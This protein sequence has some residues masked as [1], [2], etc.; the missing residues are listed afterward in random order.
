[1][2]ISLDRGLVAASLGSC[3]LSSSASAGVSVPPESGDTEA[4]GGKDEAG[5]AA[6]WAEW[7]GGVPAEG[8]V[9]AGESYPL[10]CPSGS[11]LA[12]SWECES[13][14]WCRTWYRS[15]GNQAWV[16]G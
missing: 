6:A 14:W 5:R 10:P 15:R 11:V 8:V 4:D 2:G 13:S 16:P 12:G 7:S 1:M 3:I 9:I